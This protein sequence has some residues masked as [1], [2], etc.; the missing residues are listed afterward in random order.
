[1]K[2]GLVCQCSRPYVCRKVT[3]YVRH[4]VI[5]FAQ[6]D[7]VYQYTTILS[8]ITLCEDLDNEIKIQ[9]IIRLNSLLRKK[10]Q[11]LRQLMNL[12]TWEVA[13]NEG[14]GERDIWI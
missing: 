8:E 11:T 4:K 13:A 2:G 14:A 7:R 12:S 1:M 5:L 9:N 3:H 10:G 6:C